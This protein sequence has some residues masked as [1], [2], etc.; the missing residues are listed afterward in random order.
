MEINTD[1]GDADAARRIALEI[2]L[3]RSHSGQQAY[4]VG[5]SNIYSAGVTILAAFAPENRFVR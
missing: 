1:G 3:F 4:C 2:K 5:K